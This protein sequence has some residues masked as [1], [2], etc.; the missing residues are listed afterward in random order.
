MERTISLPQDNLYPRWMES[1]I[2]LPQD[3]PRRVGVCRCK[4]CIIVR[5]TVKPTRNVPHPPSKPSNFVLSTGIWTKM[6]VV[7]RQRIIVEAITTAN[8][9]SFDVTPSMQ[10]ITAPIT[11]SP[12]SHVATLKGIIFLPSSS[13]LSS[14]LPLSPP[15]FSLNICPYRTGANTSFHFPCTATLRNRTVS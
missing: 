3:N 6:N 13:L 1:T 14:S 8:V 9:V 4:Y 10:I 7:N 5:I 15:S 2:S 11:R 12:M